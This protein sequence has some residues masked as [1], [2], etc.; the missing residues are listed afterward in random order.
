MT[1]TVLHVLN[2]PVGGATQGVLE[3]LR[4]LE[5]SRYR[6]VV[7]S[8]REP[9]P[10]R[11]AEIE[12]VADELHVV[13]MTWWNSKVGLP[14]W[15]RPVGWARSA[16]RT[17][18]H[19]V[20]VARLA[21]LIRSRQ[22]D[23][24]YTNT[25]MVLD[26]ALAARLTGRPHLWH[27]KEWMGRGARTRFPLP[28]RALVRVMGDGLSSRVVAMT[29]FIAEVFRREGAGGRV[30]V[31]YDGVDVARFGA[32]NGGEGLRRE[33]GLRPDE[34][35]VAM[36]A[37]LRSPWKKHELFVAMA[38]RLAPRLPDAR[39]V[40]FGPP[41]RRFR[42]PAYNG[43]YHHHQRLIE[44]ARSA[45]ISDRISI[46]V[47]CPDIP[48]M[49]E[50][51]DVLVHPCDI[52]PFGRVAIE[53]MA[54]RRPVVG[55]DRGGIAESVVH[56]E[57]GLLVPPDDVGALA[58]ATATLAGDP[59]LRTRMGESGRERAETVFSLERHVGEMT[60]VYEEALA[61]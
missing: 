21:R 10:P 2:D 6:S 25:A 32:D 12:A 3:L 56:G 19:A 5:G 34:L 22:V 45:G 8:P 23:L 17:G 1:T 51:V 35:L 53:A 26:G 59:G 28:D 13:P 54:A 55:P 61:G 49:M 60:R 44:M 11:R 9:A 43:G 42:N 31:V 57:T 41:P 18:L 36:A 27:V 4:G 24:V 52:E 33:L 29:E 37:A 14:A 46:G 15:Y 20:P 58:D 47:F 38:A 7:V 50:A 48:R 40:V 30:Q 39:F 16:A